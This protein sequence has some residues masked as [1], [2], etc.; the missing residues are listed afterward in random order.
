MAMRLYLRIAPDNGGTLREKR[1]EV[2]EMSKIKAIVLVFALV[3]VIGAGIN[4][5]TND[6]ITTTAN[7]ADG[8]VFEGCWAYFPAGPCYDIYRDAQG[9]YWI[10]SKCGQTKNPGPKTCRMI[11]QD[12]LNHGYWCS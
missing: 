8:Y 4:L 6:K 7:A 11:S 5:V 12:T 10:C 2:R 1:K 3:V 9:I